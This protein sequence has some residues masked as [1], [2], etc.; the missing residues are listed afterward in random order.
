MCCATLHSNFVKQRCSMNTG[1][2]SVQLGN[3][4]HTHCKLAL[5]TAALI[6]V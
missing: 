3:D 5:S 1:V 6:H 4:I 2:D